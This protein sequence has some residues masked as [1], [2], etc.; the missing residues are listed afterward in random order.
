MDVLHQAMTANYHR[1]GVHTSEISARSLRTGGAMAI[2]FGKIDINS[3]RMMDQWYSDAMLRY[4]HMQAQPIIGHY[5]VKMFNKRTYT[6]QPN[7]NVP[8]IDVYDD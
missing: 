5:A 7:E 6:F 1:T 4:L 2:L 3:I 8:I